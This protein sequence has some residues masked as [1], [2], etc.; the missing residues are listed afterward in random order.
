MIVRCFTFHRAA[1]FFGRIVRYTGA[2]G[3]EAEIRTDDGR[4]VY[5]CRG[6][7]EGY[8]RLWLG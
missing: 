6:A 5:L 2:L 1:Y 3:D 4:M 8:E 7:V